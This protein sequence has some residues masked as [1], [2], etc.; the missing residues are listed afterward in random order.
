MSVVEGRRA[1]L[2][3]HQA[4]TPGAGRVADL[5]SRVDPELNRLLD[6]LQ[7]GRLG[8]AMSAATGKLGNLRDGGVVFVAP[9]DDGFVL[10]HL[11]SSQR[12]S[13]PGP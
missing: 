3:Q 1:T 11:A 13:Q 2:R 7:G 8:V 10:V 9:V 4:F 6:A 5:P 12:V